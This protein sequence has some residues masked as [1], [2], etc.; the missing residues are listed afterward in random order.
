MR[1]S[2][3]ILT[4]QIT[5]SHEV[6]LAGAAPGTPGCRNVFI[7]IDGTWNGE[8]GEEGCQVITNVR[9][10]YQCLGPDSPTQIA[11]YFRG[12]G[13]TEDYNR[14]QRL[15]YGFNGADELRIRQSA[16]ATI[17]KEY[18]PGDNLFILGF[19]RG[20][21]CARRLCALLAD[22]QAGGLWSKISIT[23]HRFSNRITRQAEN[24]FASYE[25]GGQRLAAKVGFLGCWDT[26]GAFILPTRFPQSPRL[27]RFVNWWTSLRQRWRGDV[28]FQNLTVAAIVERAVHCVA[29][30]ETRNAFLPT[31]MNAE[32]RVEEVWFPGV[33]S[34]VGGG[35]RRDALGRIT[36]AFMINRLNAYAASRGLRPIVWDAA[37]LQRCTAVPTGTTYDFHFHGLGGWINGRDTRR[38]RVRS[39]D[40]VSAAIHPKIH[41]S[42][43]DLWQS[44]LTFAEA[45]ARHG[46]WP[47]LYTPCNVKELNQWSAGVKRA[48][49]AW[50]FDWVDRP[51][52]SHV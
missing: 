43:A 10:L 6:P 26:V 45:E 4:E 27:D 38:I 46:R 51:P 1:L 24:R 23:W 2:D 32:E 14:L 29:I 41:W 20:A 5:T 40:R 30:D 35:Y 44:N 7:L 48:A 17:L 50:P 25:T 19:S 12:V 37:E 52:D 49:D 15:W 22:P 3:E 36:L 33:H 18:K 9:K 8:L 39:N 16:F 21:A 42:V 13:N 34:D 28:P 11:R 31:L 47:I